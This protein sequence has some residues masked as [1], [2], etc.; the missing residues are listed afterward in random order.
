MANAFGIAGSY[1]GG[2][3]EFLQAGTDTKR[4]H[5]GKCGHTG[6]IAA[7]LARGG[8]TGP[9]TIFDGDYGVFKAYSDNPNL[10]K[11]A[12]A[13]GTRF[14]ILDTS[15]KPLPLCDGNF[16]P[17]EA[18]LALIQENRLEVDEIENIHCRMLPSLIPYVINF[19]GDE[20]RK[21][22]PITDLDAQMSIPYTLAVAILNNGDVW[23]DDFDAARYADAKVH[24]LSD[25][26]TV[27]GDPELARDQ[28]RRPITMPTVVTI[29]ATRG[30]SFQRRVEHHHGDPRNPLTEEELIA[31]FERC[32]QGSLGKEKQRRAL[33][34]VTN[35]EGLEALAGLMDCL[36]ADPTRVP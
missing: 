2:T 32:A 33:E 15:L 30:R 28:P 14:D 12:E 23:L 11:L 21:Y 17:I 34:A 35:L 6:A 18:T 3:I 13:L 9:H 5:P 8:M 20:V 26:I 10:A 16:A 25:K 22:R 19:Q 4:L 36:V 24:A 7:L 31:K 27:E 29:R 1:T